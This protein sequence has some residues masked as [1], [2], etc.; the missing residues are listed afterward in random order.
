MRPDTLHTARNLS[1][2]NENRRWHGTLRACNIG[3]NGQ[4]QLCGSKGCPLCAIIK[5]SFDMSFYSTQTGKGRFGRGH[6]TSSTS[7]K[8][9]DYSRNGASSTFKALLLNKV[10][11]GRGIQMEHDDTSLTAPP[12]GYDSVLGEVGKRLNY[13]ELIVYKDEAILPSYLVIYDSP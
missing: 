5:T 9:N 6:Y 11:V 12:A 4:T 10:V 8:S 3:D 13:D 2:G 1:A 7:S